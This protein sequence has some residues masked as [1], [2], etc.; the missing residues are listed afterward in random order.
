MNGARNQA[1]PATNP[2]QQPG[3]TQGQSWS[4]N[5]DDDY[6][7]DS[8]VTHESYRAPLRKYGGRFFLVSRRISVMAWRSAAASFA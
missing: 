5:D 6:A 2:F 3:Q 1:F 7:D 4:G 8:K